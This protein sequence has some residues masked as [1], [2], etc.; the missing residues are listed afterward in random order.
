MRGLPLTYMVDGQVANFTPLEQTRRH[1]TCKT[2]DSVSQVW[3]CSAMIHLPQCFVAVLI[4]PGANVERG[5]NS[6]CG[7][8]AKRDHTSCCRPL[9]LVLGRLRQ[10]NHEFLVVLS[11]SVVTL[12][13]TQTNKQKE[14]RKERTR[15]P[16]SLA[17]T[18]S[19]W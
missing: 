6:S 19:F 10:E 3:R 12:Y 11:H 8:K 2:R 16:P 13:H 14:V 5:E 9:I 18:H 15:V 1:L 17:R 7:Q 4:R